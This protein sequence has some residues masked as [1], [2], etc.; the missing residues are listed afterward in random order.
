[1]NLYDN[2]KEPSKINNFTIYTSISDT[3]LDRRSGTNPGGRPIRLRST[4]EPFLRR[5]R[6]NRYQRAV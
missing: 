5:S 4:D 3:A 2:P 6:C 1:M